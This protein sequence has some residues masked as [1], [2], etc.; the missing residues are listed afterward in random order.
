VQDIKVK[1]RKKGQITIP[2]GVRK[3]LGVEE[4]TEL[5]ITVED[6]YAIIKP[7]KRT[8]IKES[9][10]SLGKPDEDEIEFAVTDPELL[11]Q[12]YYKKYGV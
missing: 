5:V 9:A 3:R 4:G 12:Y 10:G 8:N 11:P 6:E 2:I 7:I 1:V